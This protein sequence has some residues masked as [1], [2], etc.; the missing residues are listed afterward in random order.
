MQDHP[1]GFCV[2]GQTREH[3]S[4]LFRVPTE[5]RVWSSQLRCPHRT[6]CF[7]LLNTHSALI[8]NCEAYGSCL[9]QRASA[10]SCLPSRRPPQPASRPA[11]PVEWSLCSIPSPHPV[12]SSRWNQQAPHESFCFLWLQS[13]RPSL[14]MG[15]GDRER[16][17]GLGICCLQAWRLQR[18]M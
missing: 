13:R 14:P 1:S 12:I 4:L 9:P 5:L 7:S 8:S 16:P 17:A 18:D 15:E 10:A 2:K 6:E 3:S 11:A